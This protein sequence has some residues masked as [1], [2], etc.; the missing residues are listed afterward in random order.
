MTRTASPRLTH[1][2]PDGTARMVDVGPKPATHRIAV[3]ESVVRMKPATLRLVRSGRMKKGDAIEVAR[4]A[5]LSAAKWTSALIPLC[6]PTALTHVHVGAEIRRPRE[7]VFTSRVEA[8]DRT[9]VE[10]EALTSA[11]VAAL[12]LYDMAK[13]VDRGMEIATISLLEKSGG[14]SGHY[15]KRKRGLRKR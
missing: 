15:M 10:M 14:K 9:G 7:V 1:A 2:G 3:A 4:L 8:F 12:T 6:H 11:A 13:A 5:G